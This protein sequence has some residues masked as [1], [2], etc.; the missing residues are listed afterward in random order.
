MGCNEEC[1]EDVLRRCGTCEVY[2]DSNLAF[3]AVDKSCIS[4]LESQFLLSATLFFVF[5]ST[6]GS[7]LD[8]CVHIWY[9]EL[10]TAVRCTQMYG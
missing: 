5:F 4:S 1:T 6:R 10:E 3:V 2:G 8:A 7:G 9:P